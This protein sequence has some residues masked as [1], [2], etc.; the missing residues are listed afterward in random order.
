MTTWGTVS[1]VRGASDDILRFAAHHLDLGAQHMYIYLDEPNPRAF[2][3]LTQHPKISVRLCD[4]AFWQKRN[5]TRPEKHQVRQTALATSTYR[6]TGLDWLAHIDVD[7]F[8]WASEPVCDLLRSVPAKVPAVRVRPIEALA[9]G[10]DLYK[11]HIPKGPERETLVQRIYPNFGAFVLGGFLSHVQGKLIVRTGMKSLSLRIHNI[12]QNK[13]EVPCK[14]ELSQI[15]LCHRHA[16]DWDHWKAHYAFRLDRGSYRAGMSPNVSR[17]RGGLNK[18]E[19][20]SWIETEQGPDGLRAF[21]D[22]MS[23]S[24]PETLAQ[25][26]DHDLIRYR[27]LDLDRKVAKHFPGSG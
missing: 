23:G 9:T 6:K 16:P 17:E 4:D 13:D 11:A 15:D 12:Y 10:T 26:K 2:D 21:F 14:F 20:L 5:R 24:D 22:E 3:A 18:N 7:E 27:P 1:L 25:L 19:L 8:L